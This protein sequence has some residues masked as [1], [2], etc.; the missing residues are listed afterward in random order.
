[1]DS[2]NNRG[3]LFLL[4]AKLR[5]TGRWKNRLTKI[6]L[7]GIRNRFMVSDSCFHYKRQTGFRALEND[8]SDLFDQYVAPWRSGTVFDVCDC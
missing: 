8:F 6:D 5:T 4:A 1:M 2:V 3:S 7:A